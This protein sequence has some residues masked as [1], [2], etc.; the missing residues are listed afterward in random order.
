MAVAR[1]DGR[2]ASA[3]RRSAAAASPRPR[4]AF[5]RPPRPASA[6]AVLLRGL[7]SAAESRC[8]SRCAHQRPV[9]R[10]R[11][12]TAAGSGRSDARPPWTARAAVGDRRGFGP[13]PPPVAAARRPAS[14][15]RA[16][17]QVDTGRRSAADITTEP[18]ARL[19]LRE[20]EKPD[21]DHG[22]A[23]LLQLDKAMKRLAVALPHR[24][25]ALDRLRVAYTQ[26]VC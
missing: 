8:A 11:P 6:G 22:I 10:V 20:L 21:D 26:C 18:V 14:A 19:L 4:A 17:A 2:P 5:R 7:R 23:R 12:A 13:A 9:L 15:R 25:S 1:R 3:R 24:S 16:R